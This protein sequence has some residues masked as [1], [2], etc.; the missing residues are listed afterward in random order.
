MKCMAPHG[1]G[2][3]VTVRTR[4]GE[5]PLHTA[6]QCSSTAL[7][8][9]GVS[10]LRSAVVILRG[11]SRFYPGLRLWRGAQEEHSGCRLGLETLSF[12]LCFVRCGGLAQVFMFQ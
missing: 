9:G 1:A 12:C 3:A 6:W 8:V 7:P 11:F 5:G 4:D 10:S 2:F